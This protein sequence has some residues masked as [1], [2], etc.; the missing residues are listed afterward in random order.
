LESVKYTIIGAGVIGL[1]VADSL[2]E[3]TG[4]EIAV[5]ERNE[6]FGQETSSRNSEVIHAGIYYPKGSLKSRLCLEGNRMLYGFCRANEIKHRRCGKLIVAT[7]DHE[8][9]KI[10][11]IH[12]NAEAIG[13]PG[14][15]LISAAELPAYEPNVSAKGAIFSETTGII[16]SHNLMSALYR[17]ARE[18]GVMFAFGTEVTGIMKD[19]GGYT[20]TD[21]KGEKIGTEILMNCAGLSSGKVAALAG[22]DIK[23][24]GYTIHPC[25][26]DYFSVRG[27]RGKIEHLVYPVP[28]EE[29]YGLGV[30]ATL[31]LE[32][33][34]RLGPD[35]NYVDRIDYRV[36]ES[37][38]S[39]FFLAAGK[40]LPWLKEDLLEP[41]TSGIRPKLQGPKQDF[42]DFVIKEESDNG[43]PGFLNLIGIESPGLTASLAIGK[44]V[45]SLLYDKN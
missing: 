3:A 8:M 22:M 41:D 14:L 40:Y 20:I 9:E 24:L 18:R 31:D 27:S 10:A 19:N 37:K 5:F 36:D 15:K 28:H 2:S 16:D 6:S 38:R 23:K 12:K 39:E 1:A 4:A 34:I 17:K 25:K 42:R 43:L 32:G 26:G 44:Y 33:Y 45:R 13:V 35:A 29:G 11:S 7:N 21:S 30:H